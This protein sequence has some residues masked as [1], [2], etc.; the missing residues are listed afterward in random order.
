MNETM[1]TWL[2]FILAFGGMIIIHE[3]GHYLAALMVKVEVEEFG[4]GF[5]TPGAIAFW[6]AKGYFF[7]RNGKR[8]EIPRNFRMP[9][10]WDELVDRE[11]KITVD[12]VDGRLILRSIEAVVYEEKRQAPARGQ[13]LDEIYVDEDGN[14]I[15]PPKDDVKTEVSKKLITAGK[16]FG[17]VQ[18][19]DVIAEVH[20]GT[21]FTINWLPIGGFVRPKGENDPNIEG[22]LAAAA[23]WK[24]LVVLFAGP[25]MNLVM[26]VVLISVIISQ[27]GGIISSPLD[28]TGP[29]DILITEVVPNSPADQAGLQM[30]D[31]LRT[32][33]GQT[34]SGDKDL[35]TV[36]T[37]GKDTPTVFVVDR[38]GE[39]LELTITPRM[40]EAAGRPMIGIAYCA[41]CEF[42]PITNPLEN[43]KYSL[44]F[45]GVQINSLVTLPVRLIMGTI[46]PEQGR[47]VGLKGIFD[48]VGQ[49]VASDVKASQEKA[50][51][52]Q[53]S[54]PSAASSPYNQPVQTLFI[55]ASLSIS[56]GIFNLFPFPALDGGRIIFVIP[57]MIFRKRIP[58]QFENYVH[59]IGM[60]LL[61]ALMLYINVRDFIDPVTSNLP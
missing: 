43:L 21:R 52:S 12:E 16:T 35:E 4:I 47:L 59:G 30:G 32:G 3:L 7:L 53:T 49:G 28:E 60:M 29:Q 41:G 38:Q 9:V 54:S 57:E 51:T 37:A 6:I 23:P 40:N 20:P 25:L 61:L 18:L 48:I 46:P 27:M 36:I 2:V 55:I 39:T 42:K 33:A 1:L 50:A 14:P 10:L 11:V 31:I 17:A 5:P 8:V 58:H 45:T 34:L 56:L 19:T 13:K 24:R 22:G 44:R 15:D 26:A